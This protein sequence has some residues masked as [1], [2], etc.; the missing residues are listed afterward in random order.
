MKKETDNFWFLMVLIGFI[1]LV[2]LVAGAWLGEQALKREVLR[3]ITEHNNLPINCYGQCRAAAAQFV[4]LT[5][6]D[7]TTACPMN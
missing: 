4:N 5:G 1:L 6:L 3:A 7:W 2:V